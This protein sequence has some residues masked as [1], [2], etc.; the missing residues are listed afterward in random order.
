VDATSDCH[1]V[2]LREKNILKGVHD[3]AL[4]VVRRGA[5]VNQM[6]VGR[7]K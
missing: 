1:P 5:R 3:V 2:Q 4:L 6:Y 7:V